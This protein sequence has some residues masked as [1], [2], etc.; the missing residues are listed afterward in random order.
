MDEGKKKKVIRTNG[1]SG[2]KGTGERLKRG[3]RAKTHLRRHII[4][5]RR[6][7][8]YERVVRLED[9]GYSG[10]AG[11]CIFSED[12]VRGFLYSAGRRVRS[13]WTG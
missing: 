5:S 2:R 10:L 4:L 6:D 7:I 3:R 12:L 8:D 13:D 11:A 9:V 1:C